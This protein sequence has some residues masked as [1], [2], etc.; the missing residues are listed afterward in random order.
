VTCQAMRNCMP[1]QLVSPF[2]SL[3]SSKTQLTLILVPH[4]DILSL[5]AFY[6]S[7]WKNGKYPLITVDKVWVMARPHPASAGVSTPTY[8]A[9]DHRDWVCPSFSRVLFFLAQQ[10]TDN[11]L[12]TGQLLCSGSPT[13]PSSSH[14]VRWVIVLDEIRKRRDQ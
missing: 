11:E 14:P 9:P 13:R 10:E 12:D 7:A 3:T 2:L 1:H 5:N 4:S 6:A 8:G